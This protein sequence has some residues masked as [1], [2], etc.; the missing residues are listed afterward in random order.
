LHGQHACSSSNPFLLHEGVHPH[1]RKSPDA[2]NTITLECAGGHL[3]NFTYCAVTSTEGTKGS[4]LGEM[5]NQAA[6]I[7]RTALA[8]ALRR[9]YLFSAL[10]AQD[11]E[12]VASFVVQKRLGKGEW[13][14]R[15]GA[16]LYR[17]LRGGPRRDQRPSHQYFR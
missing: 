10:S 3:C 15:E 16:P 5:A 2:T 13:L 9:C 1:D 12:C 4:K 17:L 11:L 6:Q 8:A 7:R 14:F